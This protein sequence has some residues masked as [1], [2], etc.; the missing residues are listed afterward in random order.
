MKQFS[1]YMADVISISIQNQSWV[2][3]DQKKMKQI[4]D[5]YLMLSINVLFEIVSFLIKKVLMNWKFILKTTTLKK[6]LHSLWTAPTLIGMSACDDDTVPIVERREECFQEKWVTVWQIVGY[7]RPDRLR[8]SGVAPKFLIAFWCKSPP[9]DAAF[10]LGY[11]MRDNEEDVPMKSW[12]CFSGMK[13]ELIKE[14]KLIT[15]ETKQK[16]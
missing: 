12:W 5:D 3:W 1:P 16:I 6:M 7:R 15:F 8:S 2:E 14:Q 10:D 4:L 9:G 13:F 11:D